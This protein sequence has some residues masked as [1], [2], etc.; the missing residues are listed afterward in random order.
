[1]S[2]SEWH[3]VWKKNVPSA[4]VSCFASLSGSRCRTCRRN[5]HPKTGWTRAS[6][7][8]QRHRKEWRICGNITSG[9]LLDRA[10]FCLFE[11]WV[12]HSHKVLGVLICWASNRIPCLARLVAIH[13]NAPTG[14][15][16]FGLQVAKSAAWTNVDTNLSMGDSLGNQTSNPNIIMLINCFLQGQDISCPGLCKLV[17]TCADFCA[18]GSQ[19][20]QSVNNC[21]YPVSDLYIIYI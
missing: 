17:Q 9:A 20:F 8:I 6:N 12:S 13:P 5:N 2:V 3:W 14:A 1:M 19:W 10:L 11:S 4:V 18:G 16:H 15:S 21:P 7:G